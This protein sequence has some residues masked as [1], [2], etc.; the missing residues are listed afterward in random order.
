MLCQSGPV[1]GQLVSP[2][3][4]R[5]SWSAA[6]AN[7][8]PLVAPDSVLL[9]RAP[10]DLRRRPRIKGTE[11][12]REGHAT[13]RPVGPHI[14]PTW[15]QTQWSMAASVRGELGVSP[16]RRPRRRPTPTATC[17][18]FMQQSHRDCCV[19]P[20]TPVLWCRERRWKRSARR[21][22]KGPP[23]AGSGPLSRQAPDP[24]RKSGAVRR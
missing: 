14:S 1:D 9:P 6:H 11:V 15:N 4:G 10:K 21:Q 2:C 8:G 16:P 3:P 19:N 13:P 18:Q 20:V 24:V 5:A 12:G 17:H 7:P 23:T 22:S